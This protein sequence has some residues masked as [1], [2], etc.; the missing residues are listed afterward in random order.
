VAREL[1]PHA[2]LRAHPDLG[3]RDAARRR[4]GGWTVNSPNL[5]GLPL[6][7]AILLGVALGFVG[8]MLLLRF[9][10]GKGDLS[11]SIAERLDDDDPDRLWDQIGGH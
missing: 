1:A 11:R 9:L 10:L 3:G 4:E 2:A 8:T 6:A 5:T 7:E